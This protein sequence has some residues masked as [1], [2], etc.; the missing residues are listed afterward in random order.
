M[1]QILS[2]ILH[3]LLT[4]F[5]PCHPPRLRRAANTGLLGPHSL[6]PETHFSILIFPS[7]PHFSV[8]KFRTL[9]TRLLIIVFTLLTVYLL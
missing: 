6:L 3:E 9:Y 7:L 5:S 2:C 1:G 4:P 8:A